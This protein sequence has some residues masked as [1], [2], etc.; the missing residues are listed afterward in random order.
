MGVGGQVF[1]FNDAPIVEL[2]VHIEG[3]LGALPINRDAVTG[4]APSLGPAGYVLNLSD[5]PIASSGTLF[6]QLRTSEGESLSESIAI[7][8]FDACDQNLILVNFKQLQP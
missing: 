3:T 5:H 6:V 8:T 4:S 7:D 1:D 2:T